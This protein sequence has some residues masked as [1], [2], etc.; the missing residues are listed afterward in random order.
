MMMSREWARRYPKPV[1]YIRGELEVSVPITVTDSNGPLT[2]SV[3]DDR[4][5]LNMQ[6][7]VFVLAR[8]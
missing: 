7:A 4:L 1:V 3:D 2:G 8:R 5:T 6:G